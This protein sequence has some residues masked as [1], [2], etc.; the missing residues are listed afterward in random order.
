M[1]NFI[2]ITRQDR[3]H[4]IINYET[5][6]YCFIN[7]NDYA[8][9]D[10]IQVNYTIS[11]NGKD[12]ESDPRY[13]EVALAPNAPENLIV[14]ASAGRVNAEHPVRLTATINAVPAYYDNPSYIWI[15]LAETYQENV[16]NLDW[17]TV[18]A[19]A[20][21]RLNAEEDIEG[22]ATRIL[23]GHD[24]HIDITV[25]GWYACIAVNSIL[26]GEIKAATELPEEIYDGTG[27]LISTALVH[28]GLREG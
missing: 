10:K 14:T 4:E 6:G 28:V 12:I 2:K 5:K 13:F 21:A 11:R 17:A 16:D 23:D 18:R 25:P 3:N 24:N 9:I 7:K 20:V 15:D 1:K 22:N 19:A 27:N 8:L 26:N